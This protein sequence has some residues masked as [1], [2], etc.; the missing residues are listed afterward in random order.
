M[1]SL[2]IDIG[3]SSAKAGWFESGKLVKKERGLNTDRVKGL[4]LSG[5]YKNIIVSSVS[6]EYKSLAANDTPHIH[7]LSSKS[8]LNFEMNYK[9]PDTLG[10]DRIAA[11]AGARKLFP[12]EDILV[13]DGGTCITYDFLNSEG[14]YFGGA[15]SPGIELKFKAL[16]NYTARLPLLERTSSA[17]LI[18]DDTKNAILSGVINGTL[19]EITE[20]IRNYQQKSRNL[21]L[22][23]CG[24]DAE[25]FAKR[26]KFEI[27]VIPDLVLYGLCAI[28]EYND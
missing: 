23:I 5:D 19:A 9:S 25:Y 11:V 3:T 8:K 16:H 1:H 27:N 18:G 6:S 22:V 17:D 12:K 13:I 2:A 20:I 15:I 28:L 26:L 7:W 21:R 14:K 10:T 4:L 24:G